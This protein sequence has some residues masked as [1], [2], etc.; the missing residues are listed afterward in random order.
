MLYIAEKIKDN[1]VGNLIDEYFSTVDGL[2]RRNILLNNL[3][4][5]VD[6][7]NS[8]IYDMMTGDDGFEK[9]IIGSSLLSL[10]TTKEGIKPTSEIEQATTLAFSKY[11][12]NTL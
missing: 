9:S 2:V 12:L 7:L 11:I 1:T 4:S 10:A 3:E 6:Q 5:T 8:K